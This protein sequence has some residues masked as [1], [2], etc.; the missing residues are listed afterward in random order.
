MLRCARDPLLR[1]R[2]LDLGRC[3]RRRLAGCGRDLCCGRFAPQSAHQVAQGLRDALAP[4]GEHFGD[5]EA[6]ERGDRLGGLLAGELPDVARDARLRIEVGGDG[7][8]ELGQRSLREQV[9][10]LAPEIGAALVDGGVGGGKGVEGGVEGVLLVG[11]C[12]HAH[13]CRQLVDSVLERGVQHPAVLF[14]PAAGGLGGEVAPRRLDRALARGSD[15]RHELRIVF[16]SRCHK[17]ICLLDIDAVPE[18]RSDHA[19]IE[20]D[21]ALSRRCGGCVRHEPTLPFQRFRWA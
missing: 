11:R 16:H 12:R 1:G 17:S 7:A 9:D 6:V 20:R 14:E 2:I 18:P 4:S 8:P 5:L 21:R 15:R 13:R 10:A 3:R 19:D